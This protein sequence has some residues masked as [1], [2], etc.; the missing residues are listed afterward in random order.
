MLDVG[1][2]TSAMTSS[3]RLGLSTPDQAMHGQRHAPRTYSPAWLVQINDEKL[4]YGE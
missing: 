1:N 3:P 4:E 2:E